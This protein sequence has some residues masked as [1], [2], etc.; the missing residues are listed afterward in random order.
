M[1]MRWMLVLGLTLAVAAA[2]AEKAEEGFRPLFNG[3]DLSGWV[4]VNTAPSTWTV[5]DGMIIC[6]GR[7]TGELRTDRMYQNFI[8][9]LEWR[10]MRPKGNAGVFV[11]ADD[12]TARGVP[13]HRGIE[14]QVLENAYGKAKWFT[15]HGDIFPIH[16]ARMRP[17]TGSNVGKPSG[18]AFPTEERSKPTPEW[19]HYRIE[20]NDGAISLAVNGKVVTKGAD[21]VPRKGYI[22]L[23]SEGGI[24]HYRG[25]RIKELP[26]TPIDP[27]H[28]AIADRG[29]RCL[30]TGVDLSGWVVAKGAQGHWR[31]SNWTFDYDGKAPEAD[32][33]IATEQALG[34]F[35][36]ILDVRRRKESETTRVL[37]RGSDKAAIVI[38]P[39]DPLMA[40][41]LAKG[42]GWTRFEGTMR[43]DRLSLSLNGREMFKDRPCTGV[44]AR[45]PIRIIP[46]G[47][48]DFANVYVR[49]LKEA[50]REP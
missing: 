7:P 10:H 1:K 30:Y 43:G 34:D 13:F 28:V 25:L 23:E 46:T 8:L 42:R 5:K 49:E 26:E 38:D 22:C 36:F 17:L 19:N 16:G 50:G 35:G 2:G 21:A 15:T 27:K 48:I 33:Q 6:S 29:F 47:P 11:W 4:P 24:A 40:K 37:L 3:K 44:P 9:E 14:V 39:A 32:A 31:P 45:G 41:H 20:C 18:R 12:I